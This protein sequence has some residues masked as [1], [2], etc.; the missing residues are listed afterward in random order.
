[1]NLGGSYDRVQFYCTTCE[2]TG[3]I[4]D[5]IIG[6]THIGLTGYCRSCEHREIAWYDLL[7]IT[8][9]CDQTGKIPAAHS[10]PVCSGDKPE[11]P[12]VLHSEENKGND[13]SACAANPGAAARSS[14][15]VIDRI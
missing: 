10:T 3:L 14:K 4:E 13:R 2:C 15:P 11:H 9:F 5:V 7:E 12:S 8:E 1:M 6:C